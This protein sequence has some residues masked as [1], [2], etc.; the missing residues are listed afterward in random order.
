MYESPKFLFAKGKETE[1]LEIL[2]KIHRINN[3][4]SDDFQVF[5]IYVFDISP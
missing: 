4:S 3:R 1:A 2:R 5:F